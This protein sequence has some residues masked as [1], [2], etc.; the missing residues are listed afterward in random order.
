[1]RNGLSAMQVGVTS[2]NY[3]YTV[4]WIKVWENFQ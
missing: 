2:N 1:M 4:D 3:F